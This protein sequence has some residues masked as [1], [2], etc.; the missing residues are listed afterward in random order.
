MAVRVISVTGSV[1]SSNG[2]PIPSAS[3]TISDAQSTL[4]TWTQT[5]VDGTFSVS[6]GLEVV[7]NQVQFNV[8][9]Q[10][11]GYNAKSTTRR[12]KKAAAELDFVLDPIN[13]GN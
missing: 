12:T 1:D 3:I 5:A 9:V 2:Q 11:L 8:Y 6:V 13:P 10:A 4:S 7:Q